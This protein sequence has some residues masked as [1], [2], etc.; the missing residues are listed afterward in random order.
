MSSAIAGQ[1]GASAYVQALQV[2]L[3]A[4]GGTLTISYDGGRETATLDGASLSDGLGVTTP[5]PTPGD[6]VSFSA[7][8]INARAGAAT[9][10]PLPTAADLDAQIALTLLTYSA[11]VLTDQPAAAAAA[12]TPPAAAV[13]TPALPPATQPAGTGRE[14]TDGPA[15]DAAPLAPAAAQAA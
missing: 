5:P 7:E 13:A 6:V 11:P 12:A 3:G 15:V 1:S 14:G 10:R 2:A 4:N 9:A 8:A